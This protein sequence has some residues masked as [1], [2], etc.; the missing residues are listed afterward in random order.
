MVAKGWEI[1]EKD[2]HNF[3]IFLH[4]RRWILNELWSFPGYF[5]QTDFFEHSNKNPNNNNSSQ[6]YLR[7]YNMNT[8]HVSSETWAQPVDFFWFETHES[9]RFMATVVL[10]IFVQSIYM[11]VLDFVERPV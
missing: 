2:P 6:F 4:S 1:Q 9:M 11:G 3:W 8:Y 10:V 5:F 7:G